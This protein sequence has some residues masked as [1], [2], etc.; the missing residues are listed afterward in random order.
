MTK[1]N[2]S[3]LI[4]DGYVLQPRAIDYSG[5]MKFPPVTREIWFYIVRRVQHKPYKKLKRGEGFFKYPKIQEALSWSVGYRQMK[6]SKTQIAK[7]LRR[8][9]EGNAI[10]TTKA[11]HG[12]VI[13]VCNYDHWQNPKNYEGNDEGNDEG[14]TKE[15]GRLQYKQECKQEGNKNDNKKS[16]STL[17]KFVSSRTEI[18]ARSKELYPDKDNDKAITDFMESCEIKGYK[19]KKFDLAFYKWV[20][21]D[22]F[23]Q[24]GQKSEGRKCNEA[25]ESVVVRL[26]S[27][28]SIIGTRE[29]VAEMDAKA[30]KAVKQY[31]V[32]SIAHAL[33]KM[34]NIPNPG[35]S[36][37]WLEVKR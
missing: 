35:L 4:K 23:N 31:G 21:D 10:E 9:R 18:L 32:G 11:T 17:A 25:E 34:N 14:T 30:R 1:D 22:R 19:Y 6:Y 36:A 12:I 15:T 29:T 20:R 7:S 33:N 26:T 5:V 37:F 8:L 28:W 3:P 24:Y 2:G 27:W 13:K 16:I